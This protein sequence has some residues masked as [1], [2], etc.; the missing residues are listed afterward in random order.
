MLDQRCAGLHPVAAVEVIHLANL[1][2]LGVVNVPAH[3]PVQLTLDALVG[4]GFFEVADEAHRRLDLVLEVRRQRPVT[5]AITSAPVVEPAVE[6]QG[7]FVG[8][9]TEEGQ[10][11]VITGDHVELIAVDHQQVATV[12]SHVHRFIHQLDVAQD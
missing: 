5:I 11:T 4:N 8:R 9:V 6:G 3:H 10:P 7:E 2:N 12:C 1:A